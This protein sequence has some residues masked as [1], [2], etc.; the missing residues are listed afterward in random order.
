[1]GQLP[2]GTKQKTYYVREDLARIVA[3]LATRDDK[4]ESDMVN[5]IFLTYVTQRMTPEQMQAFGYVQKEQKSDDRTN[6]HGGQPAH[7]HATR[8]TTEG[9]GGPSAPP[10]TKKRARKADGARRRSTK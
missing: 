3:M 8:G 1:M 5:E 4:F 6:A 9:G 2:T 7:A 10:G